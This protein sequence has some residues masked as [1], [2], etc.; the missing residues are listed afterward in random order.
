M[1]WTSDTTRSSCSRIARTLRTV[2]TPSKTSATLDEPP[3]KTC[4]PSVTGCWA[5][6]DAHRLAHEVGDVVAS[7]GHLHPGLERRADQQRVQLARR[8]HA[9]LVGLASKFGVTL[10]LTT[11]P[12]EKTV[13]RRW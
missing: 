3:M 13:T 6:S 12:S 5:C 4:S 1:S 2:S 9:R 8:L 10:C 7:R 11:E